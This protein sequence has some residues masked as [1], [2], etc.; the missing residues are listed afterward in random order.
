MNPATWLD[1]PA[2]GFPYDQGGVMATSNRICPICSHAVLF[3]YVLLRNGDMVHVK[4]A[5][6]AAPRKRRGGP[7]HTLRRMTRAWRIRLV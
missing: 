7:G 4:C 1:S 5:H 3:G 6:A 2:T